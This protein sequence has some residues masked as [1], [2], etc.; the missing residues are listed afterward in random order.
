MPKAN[1]DSG[2]AELQELS[3]F[4]T[5]NWSCLAGQR[6]SRKTVHT[7]GKRPASRF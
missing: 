4:L 6:V 2:D 7:L 5:D 3:N 1:R